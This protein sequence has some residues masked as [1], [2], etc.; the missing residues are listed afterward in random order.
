MTAF[1]RLVPL[2][3]PTVRVLLVGLAVVLAGCFQSLS[4]LTVRA[5]G[6]ATLVETVTLSQSALGLV[7]DSARTDRAQLDAR[8]AALGPGVTLARLVPTD[9]GYTA[10]FHV[11]DVRTLRLTMPE[12]PMASRRDSAGSAPFTFAFARGADG[13]A[14]TLGVI[15]PEPP[16][17][18]ADTSAANPE[19][20]RQAL[21]MAR[22]LL[23]D[24]RLT[25]RVEVEGAVEHTDLRD[26]TVLDVQMG[27]LLDL[28]AE[29]P[30]LVA[31]Q[32]PPLDAL[33][34]LSEGREGLHVRTPGTYTVRFR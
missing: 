25:L 10:T 33:A 8:A 19:Q 23:G 6:S 17:A 27:A 26:D 28:M 11:P 7:P 5:D 14:H 9:D 3:S 18:A 30:E 16:P 22:M 21:A 13:G 34:R 15:V 12:P 4:T 1:R 31:A 24:A 29:H 2:A 32:S 20:Q